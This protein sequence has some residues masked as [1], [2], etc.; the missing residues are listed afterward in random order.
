MTKNPVFREGIRVYILEGHGIPAYIYVL[1]LLAPIE[2]LSI[3][4]QSFDP[5]A[6]MGPAKLFKI[7]SAAAMLLIVFF[8]LRVVNQEF[9]PWKFRSLK[10]W[11]QQEGVPIFQVALGQFAL[12]SVHTL[13]F[14]VLCSPLLI[15]AGAIARVTTGSI[16]LTLLLLLFYSLTYGVWGL[17]TVTLWENRVETRQAFIRCFLVAVLLLTA[18]FFPP[19]NPVAFLLFYLGEEIKAPLDLGGWRASVPVLHFLF[20]F[21]L[22]GSGLLVYRWVLRKEGSL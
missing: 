15:W 9:V 16:L 3:F 7:V 10:Q 5:Q 13:L 8:G 19:L 4:L 1:I 11:H 6:W 17:A 21:F 18:F 14:V 20:H 12:L 2:F 22:L